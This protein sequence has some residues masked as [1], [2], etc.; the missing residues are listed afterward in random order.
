MNMEEKIKHALESAINI[1]HINII[2]ES[3]NHIGHAGDDGSGETHFKLMIV[4]SDFI[5]CNSMQR[6]R[7]VNSAIKPLFS[8][9][10][11]AIS[12]NLLTLEEFNV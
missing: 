11:H 2:N 10:L 5:E 7:I 3:K 8:S 9:G 4:S 12:V 1:H 6:Q